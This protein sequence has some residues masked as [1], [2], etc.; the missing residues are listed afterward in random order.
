MKSS[1]LIQ[2]LQKPYHG[3]ENN[4]FNWGGGYIRGGFNETAYKHLNQIF[5]FD[6]MGSAEFEF[7]EVPKSMERIQK[8]FNAGDGVTGELKIHGITVYYLCHKPDESEVKIRIKE[9][10]QNKYRLKEHTFFDEAL[11]ARVP[12][13]IVPEKKD[14]YK[15]AA[16][17]I[18]WLDIENHFMFFLDKGA[19]DKFVGVK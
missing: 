15:F 1:Y 2:R 3:S 10:S 5:R 19:F 14:K 7:G 18:G 12:A 11:A 6:Y 17:F 13:N 9:L 8:Y 4:P 16:E